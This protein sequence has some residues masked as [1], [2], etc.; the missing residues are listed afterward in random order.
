MICSIIWLLYSHRVARLTFVERL[1]N[2][3]VS[4][5]IQSR[6]VEISVYDMFNNTSVISYLK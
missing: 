2:C 6:V 5:S 1:L 3:E 4:C